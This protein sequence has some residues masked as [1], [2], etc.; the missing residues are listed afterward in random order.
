MRSWS[1]LFLI[2]GVWYCSLGAAYP[3]MGRI[4]RIPL[5]GSH[6]GYGHGQGHGQVDEQEQGRRHDEGSFLGEIHRIM[7]EIRQPVF[8]G[9]PLDYTPCPEGAKRHHLGLCTRL[10][11]IQ[12]GY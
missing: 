5:S 11:K 12:K 3:G 1:I 6:G 7:R 10:D 8:D 2:F 9:S 4:D